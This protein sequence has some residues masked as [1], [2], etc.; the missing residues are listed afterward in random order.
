MRMLLRSVAIC[1]A[2]CAAA[3]APFA[4]P[5]GASTN[6]K[7]SATLTAF[8]DGYNAD[9]TTFD[10]GISAKN[11]T[12]TKF[13]SLARN[14]YKQLVG[15]DNELVAAHWPSS[16]SR[17][18]KSLEADIANMSGDV[19]TLSLEG[20]SATSSA[21]NKMLRDAASVVA[22][23]HIVGGDVGVAFKV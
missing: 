8:A 9:T 11:L 7:P 15:F 3:V 16:A 21:A 22:Q 10:R 1:L 4:L 20:F 13:V 19:L 5:A 6:R 2:L 23:T 17:A 18:A 14:Y 12:S